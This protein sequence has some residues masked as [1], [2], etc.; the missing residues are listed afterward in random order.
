MEGVRLKGW[1]EYVL[2]GPDGDVKERR[3]VSNLVVNLGKAGIA[4]LMN[5]AVATTFRYMA[6][7]TATSATG[8]TDTVLGA[9]IGSGGGARVLSGTIDR[10]T[11]TVAN[12]TARWI[13]TYTFTAAFAVGESAIFDSS[14][15]GVMLNRA[16]FAVINAS[17]S[18]TLQVTWKVQVS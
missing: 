7:G 17:S 13:N 12:D 1:A 15:A 3:E 11:T 16:P 8:A 10:T 14:S 4:G 5:G 2:F 18:D 9:E 6:I